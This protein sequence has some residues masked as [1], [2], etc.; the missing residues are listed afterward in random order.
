[1]KWAAFFF[2]AGVLLGVLLGLQLPDWLGLARE[3]PA[4]IV[5]KIVP[6]PASFDDL[7]DELEGAEPEEVATFEDVGDVDSTLIEV[8]EQLLDTTEVAEGELAPLA[9]GQR[10][11]LEAAR[12]LA[13][14]YLIPLGTSGRP[15]VEIEPGRTRLTLYD[16][17]R[18]RGLQLTYPH[19]E[20]Q[21]TLAVDGQA[22]V[23]P[24]VVGA[25]VGLT[26][27]RGALAVSLGPAVAWRRAQLEAASGADVEGT[28]VGVGAMLTLRWRPFARQWYR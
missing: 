3:L 21:L 22:V 2:A 8:P 12:R 13:R 14:F 7:L 10:I 25:G 9:P 17:R 4:R 1:M 11:G 15:L 27:E 19:P 20:P 28:T 6:R 24:G 18:G 16:Q 23:L 26:V 5:P